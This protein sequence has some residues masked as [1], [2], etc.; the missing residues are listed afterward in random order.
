[1]ISHSILASGK[2]P[3]VTA[4]ATILT[5]Q[6]AMYTLPMRVNGLIQMVMGMVTM[7]GVT[8]ETRSP[9]MLLSGP[10]QM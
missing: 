5:V 3:M 1:M 2:I 7:I 4:S 10:M 8:T 9:E 6:L